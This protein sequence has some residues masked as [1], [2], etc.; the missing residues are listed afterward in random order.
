MPGDTGPEAWDFDLDAL[1]ASGRDKILAAQRGGHGEQARVAVEPQTGL[2]EEAKGRS[3][4]QHVLRTS[5]W[6]HSLQHFGG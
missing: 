2:G 4:T 1:T 6:R 3:V 5:L